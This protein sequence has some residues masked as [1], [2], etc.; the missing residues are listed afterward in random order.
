[1]PARNGKVRT[2]SIISIKNVDPDLICFLENGDSTLLWEREV[3][4]D[5][6]NYVAVDYCQ[7]LGPG[8]R[9]RTR[10]AHCNNFQWIPR[11]LCDPKVLL[12]SQVVDGS[13]LL[14]AQRGS[15]EERGVRVKEERCTLDQLDGLPRELT[16]EILRICEA[17]QWE[18]A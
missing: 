11:P 15:G 5:L 12:C 18:L 9:K 14:S 13:H 17:H 7:F 6:T 3:A 8:C 10:I 1:M 2:D 16:E 4:K